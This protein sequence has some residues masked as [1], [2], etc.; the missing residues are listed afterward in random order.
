MKSII[1]IVLIIVAIVAGYQ[2]IQKLDNSGGKVDILGVEISA[3]DKGKKEQ[4]Y[5]YIGVGVIAL[6][7]GLAMLRSKSN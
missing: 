2:G 4:A 5:I 7:A 6:L 1:G 3:Q